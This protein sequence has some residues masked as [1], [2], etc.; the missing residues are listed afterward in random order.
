[1]IDQIL[2]TRKK[3]VGLKDLGP[4]L[5]NQVCIC[6]LRAEAN[7]LILSQNPIVGNFEWF[8]W[9]VQVDV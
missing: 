1:M 5:K 4:R 2:Y 8:M 7:L 3:D 9:M 6:A